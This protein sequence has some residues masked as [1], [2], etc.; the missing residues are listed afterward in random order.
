M[1]ELYILPQK[2]ATAVTAVFHKIK[3]LVN[4][5][6]PCKGGLS[7]HAFQFVKHTY[8]GLSVFLKTAFS[9]ISET[10]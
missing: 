6:A 5:A 7:L 9:S 2:A 4:R 1:P 8:A 3:T 10:A